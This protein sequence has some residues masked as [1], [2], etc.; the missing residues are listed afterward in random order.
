MYVDIMNQEIDQSVNGDTDPDNIE[1]EVRSCLADDVR[2][3]RGDCKNE[4]EA[5]I[6]LKKPVFVVVG[7]VMVF[8]PIPQHT[9]HQ[10]FM[11]GPGHKFH[12][13]KGGNRDEHIEENQHRVFY[14]RPMRKKNAICK[15]N[16]AMPALFRI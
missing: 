13:E 9:V 7:S 1:P 16:K 2:K 6:F 10:V 14:L 8:M 15:T 4:K 5:V 3:R 12:G 11:G